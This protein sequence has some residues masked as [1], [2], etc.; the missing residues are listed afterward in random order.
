VCI[1]LGV[2][3][4]DKRTEQEDKKT[5]QDTHAQAQDHHTGASGKVPYCSTEAAHTYLPA[6]THPF[7][8]PSPLNASSLFPRALWTYQREAAR[9]AEEGHGPQRVIGGTKHGPVLVGVRGG[10]LLCLGGV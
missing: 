5:K 6:G 1:A 10:L 8:S 3:R 4:L 7:R 2:C 9:Q